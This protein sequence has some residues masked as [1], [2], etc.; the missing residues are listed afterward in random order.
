MTDVEP[1][2]SPTE[3]DGF[4][5]DQAV[6]VVADTADNDDV[7][8]TLAI[9]AQD[10]VVRR[11]AVDDAVANAS[12]V[13]TTA[14]TR[15]ELAADKLDTIQVTADSAPDLA[16]VSD[17]VHNFEARLD[18]ID[19]RADA[20]GGAIQDVLAMKE[21]GDLYE[22]AQRI[23]RVTNAATD[24]QQTADDFQLELDAFEAWLTDPDRRVEQLTNDVDALANSVTE[25]DD[26]VETFDGNDDGNGNSDP[27]PTN[28]W[29]AA[30]IRHRVVSLMHADLQAELA[31]VRSWAERDGVTSPSGIKSQ[32]DE[33][34]R[35]HTALEEQLSV[36]ALPEWKTRFDE[37]LTAID[38]ALEEM[39][40]PV[41]WPDVE[42]V[43]AEHRPDIE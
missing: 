29:L 6:S 28:R 14:E 41:V 2:D 18:H 40:P 38:D 22:I 27:E 11:G 24:V 1:D 19:S 20:L 17:R 39:E 7:R 9:V 37:Q 21:T 4:S 33:I 12:M 36:V 3:L 13:V 30:T 42:A 26:A 16:F 5:L 10:G 35:D 25:L 23:K 34:Q 15:V 8:E 32:L 43:V 31:A